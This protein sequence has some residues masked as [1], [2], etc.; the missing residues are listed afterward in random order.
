MI[1]AALILN[2][3]ARRKRRRLQ[4]E[5]DEEERTGRTVEGNEVRTL[6]GDEGR[7]LESAVGDGTPV[8]RD[9]E[10]ARTVHEPPAPRTRTTTESEKDGVDEPPEKDVVAATKG[11]VGCS[12]STDLE[13]QDV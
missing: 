12:A 7:T 5:R 8:A 6:D 2:P 11:V 1:I 4:A 9:A 10:S 3:L 13:K